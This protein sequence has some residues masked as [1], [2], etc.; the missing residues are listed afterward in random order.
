MLPWVNFDPA[1]ILGLHYANPFSLPCRVVLLSGLNPT[2]ASLPLPH[3]GFSPPTKWFFIC[4]S[5]WTQSNTCRHFAPGLVRA[6]ESSQRDSSPSPLPLGLGSTNTT[7][8]SGIE[9]LQPC[10]PQSGQA[11][12]PQLSTLYGPAVGGSSLPRPSGQSSEAHNG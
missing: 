11:D 4:W 5:L 7:L 8:P 6:A 2:S 1:L 3:P 12:R 10:P 9:P